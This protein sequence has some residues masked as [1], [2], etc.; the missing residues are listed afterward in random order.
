LNPLTHHEILELVGPFTRRGR[1]VDL[2]A[3]DRLLRRVAFKSID[4]LQ[5]AAAL[6]L[7]ETLVLDDLGFGSYRLTRRLT[8]MVGPDACLE[9]VGTEPA[10]LLARIDAVPPQRQF[11]VQE[12]VVIALS[13]RLHADLGLDRPSM[14]F[15]RGKAHVAGLEF[16]LDASAAKRGPA[17]VALTRMP[18]DELRLPQD[19]LAV[20]GR[21]W[22]RLRD[23]GEGWAGELRLPGKEPARTRQA[24][25]AIETAALHIARMLAE[26]PSRFHERWTA[27]RWRVFCRRLVPLAVCI[28]LIL[29]AA[30][31]PKLHLSES[32]GLRMLML[33]SPPILMI[34]FFGLREIPVVEIPPL[35]RRAEAASWRAARPA[36][37]PTRS[38]SSPTRSASSPAPHPGSGVPG[39]NA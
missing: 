4:H 16:E 36:S 1:H 2:A 27:A 5:A 7:R 9:T 29:C 38:A 25:A 30:A 14:T 13:F 17:A 18:E 19:T 12:G 26:P 11:R 33:N 22:S 28:G 15:T 21:R 34:L 35:P 24:Q 6:A 32:S 39:T 23:Y 37:S 8:P 31:A 10:E 3:T 20:L